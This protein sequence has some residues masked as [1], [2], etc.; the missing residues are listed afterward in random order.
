MSRQKSTGLSGQIEKGVAVLK[1]GGVIAFPTD[2]VYGIGA[3]ISN[4]PAVKRIFDI[5]KRPLEMALP[6][7][8]ADVEQMEKVAN[9]LPMLACR[10]VEHF[11][12][13]AL[14]L[15]LPK[16]EEVPDIVTGSGKTVA[17]R[18]PDHPVPIALIKGLGEP[19]TGTSANKS[20][21]KSSTTAL[22]VK[23]SL[24]D[25]VDFIID[26]GES[27]GTKESTII[28]FSGEKPKMVREGAIKRSEIEII[29]GF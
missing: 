11:L 9:R 7:L 16:S 24:G 15:I 25:S 13:G 3:C 29:C 2:T 22:E 18:I 17:V 14:T 27:P 21:D 23:R 1:E 12:P 4:E 8:V 10:L 19:I 26:G 28:D 5:K 6:V 20:G